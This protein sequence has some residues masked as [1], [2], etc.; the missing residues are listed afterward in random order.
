[1]SQAGTS[2]ANTPP[3]GMPPPAM[4]LTQ[5]LRFERTGLNALPAL[6]TVFDR[7]WIVRIA[8][9]TG[10]ASMKRAN[11]VTC[12]DPGDGED[13]AA[14]IA[15]IEGIYRRF[16]LPAM[17]RITPLTPP[18]LDAALTE[19]GYPVEDERILLRAEL[20]APLR[21]L[22]DGFPESPPPGWFEVVGTSMTAQR[23]D[24]IR[25]SIALLAL[26]SFFPLLKHEG[27][28]ACGVR[29]TIDGR[30]AAIFDIATIPAARRAGLARQVMFEAMTAAAARGAHFAWLQIPAANTAAVELYRSLGFGEAYRYRFRAK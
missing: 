26:P 9:G 16:H 29:V 13:V 19:R 22:K 18:A 11:S 17:F 30:Y 23:L 1:M 14:R 25:E 15:W 12:L 3:S 6:R 24:E 7:S 4:P 10:G 21:A 27:Q 28:P 5:V 20:T 8:R 2:S